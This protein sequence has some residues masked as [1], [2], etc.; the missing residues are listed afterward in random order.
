MIHTP[1]QAYYLG[2]RA[3]ARGKVNPCPT[4]EATTVSDRVALT[5]A[6]WQGVR[7]LRAETRIN[8][9]N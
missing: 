5:Q 6:Y 2:R 1:T 9:E 4:S 7:D 8:P 3:A